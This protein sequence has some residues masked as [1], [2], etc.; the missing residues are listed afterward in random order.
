MEEICHDEYPGVGHLWCHRIADRMEEMAELV[1]VLVDETMTVAAGGTIY[2]D[3]GQ[4]A[5][6]VR[7]APARGAAS[8][9]CPPA[10]RRSR[11]R[12]P[13][14][15]SRSRCPTRSTRTRAPR[16]DDDAP[17]PAPRHVPLAA[18]RADEAT[19]S[20]PP[21][22]SAGPDASRPRRHG[23]WST[24]PATT[25]DKSHARHAR[26]RARRTSTGMADDHGARPRPDHDARPQG[27]R[28]PPRRRAKPK[29]SGPRQ[30]RP[31]ETRRHGASSSTLEGTAPGR[32]RR[33]AAASRSSRR[34]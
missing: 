5:E 31:A 33:R 13:A 12:S 22:A 19:K 23:H 32:D 1:A 3:E 18:Q 29:P 9:T 24:E 15:A 16:R 2:D 30:T 10:A 7:G 4:G 20:G 28:P 11:S 14:S 8:S 34:R 21:G 27:A 17:E 25:M 26:S 6:G